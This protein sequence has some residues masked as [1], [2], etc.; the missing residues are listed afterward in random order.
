MLDLLSNPAVGPVIM[1]FAVPIVA[2]IAYYWHETLKT[3][4]NNDLKQSMVERGMS[5]QEIEQVISAG[6]KPSKKK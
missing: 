2:I 1:V 3:R 4:S 5:A 6:V